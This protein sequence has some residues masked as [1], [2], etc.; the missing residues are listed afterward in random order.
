MQP[1]LGLLILPLTPA[2]V[3]TVG[4]EP[5]MPPWPATYDMQSSTILQPSNADGALVPNAVAWARSE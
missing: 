3:T 2:A 5:L 1:L 4:D